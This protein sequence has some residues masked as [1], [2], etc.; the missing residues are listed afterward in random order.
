MQETKESLRRDVEKLREDLSTVYLAA[1]GMHIN[2][3]MHKINAA[4]K[5]TKV[6]NDK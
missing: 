2:K 5:L 1:K 4:E 6:V 3:L